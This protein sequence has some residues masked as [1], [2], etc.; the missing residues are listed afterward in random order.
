MKKQ[1]MMGMGLAGVVLAGALVG[2][3][4][5]SGSTTGSAGGTYIPSDEIGPMTAGLD[6][7][8][9]DLV[10]RAVTDEMKK[11]GLKKDYVTA[12][13]SVDTSGTP[14]SVRVEDIQRSMEAVFNQEGSL[15]FQVVAE[16]INEGRAQE[17]IMKLK[18]F[19]WESRQWADDQDAEI[20]GTLARVDGLLVGRVSSTQAV[21]PDG[22][23][24]VM[25][26][27]VW[28]LINA[29]TG[30]LDISYEYKLGKKLA[31]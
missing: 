12:L 6:D 17:L 4:A 3:C 22:K 11:R 28:R 15:K 16:G 31:K 23:K 8:D 27:F 25:Y 30:I 14:Q 7:H 9:Y 29:R 1:V 10:V 18:K 5:F 24:Q 26:R 21:G 13:G 20:L 2:G 19:N